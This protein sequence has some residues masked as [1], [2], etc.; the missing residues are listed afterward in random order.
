M[1]EEN[2]VRYDVLFAIAYDALFEIAGKSKFS[3]DPWKVAREALDKIEKKYD[4]IE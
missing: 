3:D 4:G 2:R 1:S